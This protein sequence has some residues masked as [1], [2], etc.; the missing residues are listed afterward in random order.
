MFG[1][2]P[3]LTQLNPARRKSRIAII[4]E[5]LANVLSFA[6]GQ[7]LVIFL[8]IIPIK[9]PKNPKQTKIISIAHLL[10]EFFS[11]N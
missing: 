10:V 11:E 2:V 7:D 1:T 6:W 4:K 5:M 8:P 9:I 3:L